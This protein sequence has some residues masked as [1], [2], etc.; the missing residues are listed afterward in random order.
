MLT[1]DMIQVSS[2]ASRLS[3]RAER[4]M[5]GYSDPKAADGVGQRDDARMDP[6]DDLP[7]ESRSE[8]VSEV[9]ALLG[10][11]VATAEDLVR[12]AEPLWEAME[13]AGGL[14]DSWGGGEFCH[15]FPRTLTFIRA[16]AGGG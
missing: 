5:G 14:V 4:G 9:R 7:A 15:I 10:V 16:A 6:L 1:I 11:D 8:V 12:A 13:R 2:S 3:T